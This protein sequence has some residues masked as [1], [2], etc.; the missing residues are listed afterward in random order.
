MKHKQYNDSRVNNVTFQKEAVLLLLSLLWII[1]NPNQLIRESHWD[2][3]CY[4]ITIIFS[5]CMNKS[6]LNEWSGELW[7]A[8]RHSGKCSQAQ[9][10]RGIMGLLKKD[11]TA[12]QVRMT[13]D[14]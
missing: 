10:R 8:E 11:I 3:D 9:E 4:F 7:L 5:V 14:L 13:P 6:Q 2:R 12:V 1:R